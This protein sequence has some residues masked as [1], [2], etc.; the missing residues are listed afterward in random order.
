MPIEKNQF[1]SIFTKQALDD[2][3]SLFL[4][5]G[6]SCDVGYPSWSDMFKDCANALN[7]QIDE[8]TDYYQLGQFYA[9]TF[10]AS[11]LRK[12]LNE[13]INK[14]NYK[15]NLINE[16][17]NIG[18][19]NL[20]TTNFDN[21]LEINYRKKNI[22]VNKIFKDSDLTSIEINKRINIFKMNGDITNPDGIIATQSDFEKYAYS[23]QLMLMFF[24]RELI[25]NTFL[26][27]GYSFTD[28]LVLDCMSELTRYL[29][30][31]TTTHYTI[32]KN[33]PDNSNFKYF[34]NDL[35]Q[36]YHI[37][38]LLVDKYAEVTKILAE[39][40][41]RIRS[42]KVF[43]SGAFS[44]LDNEIEEFSHEFSKQITTHLYQNDYR[45]V[46]G[47][48]RRFGTHLIGYANEYLA[49]AGIKNIEKY[50]LVRPFVGK[51]KKSAEN[52]KRARKNVIDLCGTTIFLFGEMDKN[53]LNCNSGVLEEYE[54]ALKQHKTIIPIS[55]PG[56]ISEIIW[57]KVKENITQYPYLEGKID[58][59]TSSNNPENIAKII[60][61]IINS[62]NESR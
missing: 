5:A 49:K 14:N 39:L 30:E 2:R 12:K 45:I 15:S 40:N 35:E 56:M 18:F 36:R 54:I 1:L 46:N 19:T 47:I 32:M 58:Y 31:F 24:K 9:N 11:E 38:V 21:A 23:H 44:S 26:Y 17:M 41:S 37:N 6:G 29:G 62:V 7:I 20:W 53:A 51:E 27:I 55:Y 8:S 28:H 59:L 25:S 34:I 10:G 22:L 3:I 42:K 50:L 60:I 61:Q 16:L 48:G 43:I 13:I 4:G 33:N 52:K 57:K